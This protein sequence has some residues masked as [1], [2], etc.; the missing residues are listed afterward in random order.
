MNKDEII[1]EII[2]G[3]GFTYDKANM[4]YV[5]IP[6]KKDKKRRDLYEWRF[7]LSHDD[8]CIL[9]LSVGDFSI[10]YSETFKNKASITNLFSMCHKAA[11]F[12]IE[13]T[14]EHILKNGK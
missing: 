3:I 12:A 10:T 5:M 4:S 2:E 1:I 14:E 7:C 6:Y 11:L 9:T 8:L 13:K